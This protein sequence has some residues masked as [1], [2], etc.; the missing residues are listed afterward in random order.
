[1]YLD[2]NTSIRTRFTG[3]TYSNYLPLTPALQLKI[4]YL[5]DYPL[6][7]GKRV[8]SCISAFTHAWAYMS[9]MEGSSF[10]IDMA[11][12]NSHMMGPE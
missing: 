12:K 2:V 9:G 3:P 1:M 8:L 4:A 11:S 10:S 5:P 6:R 7:P